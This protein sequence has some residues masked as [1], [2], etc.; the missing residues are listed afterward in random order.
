[1][2]RIFRVFVPESVLV[3]LIAD[4]ILLYASFLVGTFLTMDV[5]PQ[6]FLRYDNGWARIA[7]LVLCVMGGL[8]FHDLYTNIRIDSKTLLVQ[9]AGVSLG[10]AFFLQ[11]LLVYLALQELFVPTWTMIAGS[12]LA[13]VALPC[14]R[15]VYTRAALQAA[16]SARVLFLGASP[17]V[18]EIC[19]HWQ[20]HPE[21][22]LVPIGYLDDLEGE[23]LIPGVPLTG[24]LSCLKTAVERLQPDRIVVGLLDRRNRLP[25]GQLLELRLSGIQIEDAA[26]TYESTFCRISSRDLRPAQ[27]IF[28]AELGPDPKRVTFQ[29]AYSFAIAAI[30]IAAS[31]PLMIL[32]AILI[33]LTSRGPVLFRQKRVGRN[34]VPFTL[35]KF[36]SMVEHAERTSGPVWA[37]KDDPRITPLGWWIRKLRLDELPQLF[38]VLKGEM[39]IVGPRPERPEFVRELEKR[40]PFYMQRLCVKPGITGWAQ[41]NHKYGDTIEDAI[42]KL[43]YDLYY[44]KNLA[45]ALDCLIMFHT[46]KVML[47]SRGAQ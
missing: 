40:I 47:L 11:A 32:I 46:A 10:A 29:S 4:A 36:R 5:D 21:K 30:A 13:L 16:G 9:Q 12:S 24:P 34:G 31:V 6:V 33:K 41:I 28:S 3:L 44:I 14:W 17:L 27:L 35:Y 42:A 45:P 19:R 43:E 37:T 39:S 23:S 22:G 20:E 15:I 8:Y 7:I 26:S 38:N 18:Q 25:V 2:I 1:M